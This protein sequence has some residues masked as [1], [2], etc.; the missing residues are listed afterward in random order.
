V[1]SAYSNAVVSNAESTPAANVINLV[2]A[3]ILSMPTDQILALLIEERDKL[4]RAIE[5]LQGPLNRRGRPPKNPST[6]AATVRT[7]EPAPA[8]KKRRIFTAAQRKQQ[9]ERMKAFWAAKKK[10]AAK[11]QSKAASKKSKTSKAS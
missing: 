4:N 11:P 3:K 2:S 6:T 7:A 5:V 9:A 1:Y 8:K 10:A